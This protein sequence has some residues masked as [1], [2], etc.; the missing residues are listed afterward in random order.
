MQWRNDD[1]RYGAIAKMFHWLLAVLVIGMLAFGFYM[2]SL[3][4]SQETVK[5]YGLHK[6]IGAIILAGM[7]LRLAWRQANAV[8]ALPQDM[9]RLKRLAA[10]LTHYGLY[11]LLIAMPLSG[12]LMSSAA[13]FPV[14]VFG[15]LTL[16]D[17][18][19]SDKQLKELFEEAHELMAF[20]IIALVSLHA[21]AAL[22]HHFV[23]KDTILR[24]MLPWSKVSVS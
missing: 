10:H 5:L 7:V 17:L 20:A 6:S 2:D 19:A 24:R 14:S 12:W 1:V 11:A 9:D 8:P 16:P 23:R 21:L 4:F 3:A 13:G 15:W 18:I 22:Y